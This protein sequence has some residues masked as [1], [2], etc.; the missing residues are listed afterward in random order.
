MLN[1]AGHL[2]EAKGQNEALQTLV[3]EKDEEIAKLCHGTAE[4]EDVTGDC[5]KISSRTKVYEEE[6]TAN[7]S[8]MSNLRNELCDVKAELTLLKL[9]Q[10]EKATDLEISQTELVSHRDT[11]A[12]QI[13]DLAEHL[14]N[15]KSQNAALETAVTEK[16]VEVTMLQKQVEEFRCESKTPETGVE[17]CHENIRWIKMYEEE[18]AANESTISNLRVELC[19]AKAKLAILKS[20]EEERMTELESTRTELASQRE[21]VAFQMLNLAGHLRDAKGQNTSLQTAVEEKE[22]ELATL[23]KEVEQFCSRKEETKTKL[24]Q[25]LEKFETRLDK[26][27]KNLNLK[28]QE[29]EQVQVLFMDLKMSL[30]NE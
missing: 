17:D 26:I 8:T 10:A 1:L 22:A 15:A 28:A 24:K 2:R 18:K 16:D 6:K 4:V 19:D 11:V 25:S 30:A 3:A 20:D 14:R 21:T 9:D 7:A 23:Q 13:L 5:L 29:E 12:L 27:L